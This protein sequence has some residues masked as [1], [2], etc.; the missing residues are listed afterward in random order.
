MQ[1]IALRFAENFAPVEGT[2]KAHEK[3]MLDNGFVWYGKRG[4]PISKDIKNIILSNETSKILLIQSGKAKRYW[5]YVEAIQNEKPDPELIPEYYR[6]RDD[7]FGTWFKVTRFEDA[8]S[9]V[10][11]HCRVTS[12]GMTLSSASK[13][14]MSPYF[15]I[16]Y[17]NQV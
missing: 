4:T 2:I 14:S 15:K 17:N 11:A 1:T 6:N 13:H 12:S 3:M 9:D 16:T 8:P 5:A 7:K 10:M